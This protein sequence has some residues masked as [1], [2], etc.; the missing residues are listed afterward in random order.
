MQIK[1]GDL[2]ACYISNTDQWQVL[3]SWGIVLEVDFTLGDILVLD[4][5]GSQMCWPHKIWK[6][7]CSKNKIKKLDIDVKLA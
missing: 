2:V 6:T 7:I 3:M 4:N 5:E 1:K